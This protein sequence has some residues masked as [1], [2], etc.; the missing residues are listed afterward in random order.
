MTLTPG[1][2]DRFHRHGVLVVPG[3]VGAP[4]R[5]RIAAEYA[6][7]LG[8]LARGWGVPWTGFFP[9]LRAVHAAGHDWFQPM[10]ISLPGGPIAADTPFHAGP[11]VFDLLTDPGVLDVVE[12]VIGPEITSNPIQHVRIKPPMAEVAADED[13]AHVT[14]TAWHQDRG[15]ALPEA[16]A[17]DM[18]TVW[19]A[20]TDA[21]EE[22]GCLIVK[23]RAG[24]GPGLLPHC[25]R[26]QT[27]IPEALLPRGPARPLP[28]RAGDVV[29]LDPMVPH[30]SLPNRSRDRCRWSFDLRYSRTGQPTGRAHFPD[31][32]A[33]SRRAPDRALRDWRDWAATWRDARARL[34]AAPH[35]PI[36][37]W[38]SDA[39]HC[40]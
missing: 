13:R 26:R 25:A 31:F 19:I 8:R 38:A 7:V 4:L 14:V 17:T 39:P 27:E 10:D 34:S 12:A 28:V 9:T 6:D 32:V 40:A 16:D 1:Q 11:A 3:V 15:V 2:V 30:A 22:T 21:T 18:V 33:R 37:R 23:P 5:Q 24:V 20:M 29:L 35:V 36:H